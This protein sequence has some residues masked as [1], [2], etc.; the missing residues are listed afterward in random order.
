MRK[1][2][3]LVKAGNR[4]DVAILLLRLMLAAVFIYHGT[5]KLF[6]IAGTIGYFESVHIPA[7]NILG[8]LVA[9]VEVS[10]G[11]LM[12]IGI[13][14]NI[15]GWLMIAVLLVAFWFVHLS[16]G[17]NVMNGGYEYVLSLIVMALAV[18]HLGHGK[19]SLCHY[20]CKEGECEAEK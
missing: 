18:I 6:D 9:A 19:Y 3:H 1:G 14:T 7:A 8:P 16:K 11:I 4:Q 10:S 12:L 20:P 2:F 5:S 17:F 13:M 15:A